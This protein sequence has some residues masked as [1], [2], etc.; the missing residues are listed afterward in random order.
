MAPIKRGQKGSILFRPPI[1]KIANYM[2]SSNRFIRTEILLGKPAMERLAQARVAVFGIGGVGSYAAEALARSGV[3]A[4]DLV[5]HDTVSE[6]N[7]NRQLIAGYDTI[8]EYKVDVMARRIASINP[9]CSVVK[10]ARFYVPDTA[11]L[12][13]IGEYDYIVDALD[14]VTAKLQ[15]IKDANEAGTPII[16]SMGAANKLDPTAF[17]VADIFDTSI[18]PLARIIRKECRKRGLAGCKAVYSKE[19]ALQ[20]DEIPGEQPPEGRRSIPGSVA[21]VPSAVGLI[22]AGEVVRDIIASQ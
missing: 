2:T 8:G 17:E 19:P 22:V 9:D 10:H 15:L 6:T 20:P 11:S 4:L 1:K 14:T 18:C 5:D 3:G 7:I 12:F 16:S 13:P 21:F